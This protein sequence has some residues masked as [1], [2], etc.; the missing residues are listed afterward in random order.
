MANAGMSIAERKIF[1][2]ARDQRVAD[3][4][5]S[6][7]GRDIAVLLDMTT[8]S[9]FTSVERMNLPR[10]PMAQVPGQPEMAHY[11]PRRRA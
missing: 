11:K 1:F 7:S 3:L 2:A 5:P 4:W 10:R 8:E 9:V 6:M